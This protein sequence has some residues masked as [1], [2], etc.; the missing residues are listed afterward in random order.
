MCGS[1]EEDLCGLATYYHFLPPYYQIRLP[2]HPFPLII[3]LNF[4]YPSLLHA[5]LTLSA[6]GVLITDA[7][8]CEKDELTPTKAEQF[9]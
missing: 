3:K 8:V 9:S 2:L 6:A 4:T 5:T 7:L 1:C